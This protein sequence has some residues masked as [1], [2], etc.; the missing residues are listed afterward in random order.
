MIRREI[1][2]FL[3]VG[4]L[5]VLIDFMTYRLLLWPGV[6]GIDFSKG[7]AF[8]AGTVFAYFANRSWTFGFKG[9]SVG[10]AMRFILLY[11]LTLGVNVSVNA[12]MLKVMEEVIGAFYHAFLI[13]TG[14]SAIL[15]FVGMKFF[16]FR[17]DPHRACT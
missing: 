11:S 12:L 8:I 6:F 13:A 3:I 9:R 2:I 7:I 4:T 15:N 1:V 14:V 17:N 5:T 16:V 10:T